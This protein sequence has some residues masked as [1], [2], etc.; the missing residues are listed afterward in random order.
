MRIGDVDTMWSVPWLYAGSILTGIGTTL[1]G[2]ILP[3]VLITWQI[4]DGQAGMLFAAQFTGSALGAALVGNDYLKSTLRGY[5]LLMGGALSIACFTR[6]PHVPL[7][8]IFGLGL[9]LTMTATSMLTGSVFHTN[10]AAALSI[11]NACWCHGAVLCPVVASFWTNHWPA[12]GLFFALA[13]ALLLVSFVATRMEPSPVNARYD[14]DAK[15][16]HSS[17]MLIFGFAIMAFLYVG[18]EASVSGWMMTYVRRV[19]AADNA[20]SPAAAACFWMAL[21][22]G[23]ATAP[24]LLR[25][26]SDLNLLGTSL[27]AAFLGVLWLILSHSTVGIMLS[28]TWS[29]FALAPIFPLCVAKVFA[30]AN[31]SVNTKWFLGASG[32]GGALL[33]WLTGKLSDHKSSLTVGLIV[34]VAVL[35]FMLVQLFIIRKLLP[36]YRGY[37][38]PQ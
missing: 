26:M 9:G 20:W 3:R 36:S 28:A 35:W 13:F 31:D 19:V 17:R 8:F 37:D 38:L 33:P 6:P 15:H 12:A 14:S 30:L 18:V 4:N 29:G 11:L 2:C 5:L 16:G 24:W 27:F 32:L 21:L 34:P 10:R 22:C 7:F 23:R 1:L 25:R